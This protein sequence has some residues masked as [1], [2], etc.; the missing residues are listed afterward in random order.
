MSQA[1]R[2]PLY[3]LPVA[4]VLVVTLALVGAG[5]ARPYRVARLWG[6]PTGGT[7]QS[8]R[9]EVLDVV[10]D[11]G[12]V[13]ESPVG[14]G[15]VTLGLHAPGFDA[16]RS[17]PL[18]PE[19]GAELAFELPPGA[20]PLELS[21]SQAGKEL[22]RGKI[23]LEREPWVKVARRR[24]G[25]VVT[26]LGDLELRVAPMR[27][28]LAVPFEESLLVEVSRDG[29]AAT[30]LELR[31]SATGARVTPASVMTDAHGRAMLKI[32]PEEHVVSL[33]VEA[34]SPGSGARASFGLAVV[35]GALRARRE[36]SELV[37]EAP[38]PREIAYFALVT[39][40]ERLLG[41]RASFQPN[42]RGEMLARVPLPPLPAE[43][44]YAV[45]S[46]ERDLRSPAS[47]GWPLAI[48]ASGEPERTFD[49]VEALL[50]DGRPRAMLRE[51]QR[52]SRVRWAVAAFS[53]AALTIELLLLIAFT[54]R[55]DRNLDAHLE[56][57]GMD[58]AAALRLA[59]KRSPAVI[60]ALIAVALGFLLVALLGVLRME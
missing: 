37:V 43:P 39:E 52:R 33:T 28:A 13:L 22:A 40:R 44:V 36:G 58:A 12:A 25:W 56:G 42:P 31:A 55:S 41:G 34:G 38:V 16:L 27:G 57:A 17:A 35:P 11:R 26:E 15:T 49:A 8:V 60:V 45:V 53:A 5:A 54:K 6:G 46:S 20:R 18:D 47:V 9:A 3:V 48:G 29:A 32:A 50:L 14:E 59:P 24:G 51:A 30:N 19:G 1:L 4:T 21:V 2:W 10:E 23:S 7:R